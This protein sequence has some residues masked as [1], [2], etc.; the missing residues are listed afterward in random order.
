MARF[1]SSSMLQYT[2]V[3]LRDGFDNPDLHVASARVIAAAAARENAAQSMQVFGG[4][5]QTYEYLPHL[6]LKRALV[7]A[8]LGGGAAADEEVILNASAIL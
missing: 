7:L 8:S 2:A 4:Y 5:G 3:W 6:Y 1:G